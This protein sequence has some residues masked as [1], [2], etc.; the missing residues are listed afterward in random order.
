[1]VQGMKQATFPIAWKY[2]RLAP[3]GIHNCP[4]SL[5]QLPELVKNAWI[6]ICRDMGACKSSWSL[7]AELEPVV[8]R[9]ERLSREFP[10]PAT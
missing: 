4:R 10:V 3:R 2:F 8:E 1:M 7:G 9:V 5:S 6:L